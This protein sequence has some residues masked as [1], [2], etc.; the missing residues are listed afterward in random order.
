MTFYEPN[1]DVRETGEE[2]G[3]FVDDGPLSKEEARDED[4][5]RDRD[6]TRRRSGSPPLPPDGA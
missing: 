2:P 6:P 5:E 1:P 3:E 4:D